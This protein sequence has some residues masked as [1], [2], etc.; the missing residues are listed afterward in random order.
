[1]SNFRKE[2]FKVTLG[3]VESAVSKLAPDAQFYKDREAQEWHETIAR[4]NQILTDMQ[5]PSAKLPM[6]I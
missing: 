3:E 6:E 4:R 5:S 1:M 2:F